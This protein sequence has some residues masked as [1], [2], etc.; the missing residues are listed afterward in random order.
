MALTWRQVALD[1]IGLACW[2]G[3]G[4]LGGHQAKNF[5]FEKLHPKS[6]ENTYFR[7]PEPHQL[8]PREARAHK[9]QNTCRRS[10]VPLA[11][12]PYT[13]HHGSYSGGLVDKNVQIQIQIRMQI[14]AKRRP[15]NTDS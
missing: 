12:G 9:R 1:W 7:L 15:W 4:P 6:M 3:S 10:G 5:C 8:P 13:M 11:S 2:L 14:W